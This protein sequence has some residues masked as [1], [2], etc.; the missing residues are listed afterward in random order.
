M[1]QVSCECGFSV[2]DPDEDR[3]VELTMQHVSAAHP[4]LVD[5]VTP[6]VVRGWVEVVP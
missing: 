2:Q 4:D 5:S 6:G 1:N 3:V